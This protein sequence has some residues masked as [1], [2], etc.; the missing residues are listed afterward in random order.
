MARRFV[1]DYAQHFYIVFRVLI[2]LL[3]LAH[4]LQKFGI[5]G[6][7]AVA[8]G[9]L[10]WFAGVIELIVGTLVT[11]GLITRIAALLG[12]VE[13]VVAYFLVHLSKGL[14]P[15]TNNGE[16]AVLYFAA[17]LIL[18]AYGYQRWGLDSYF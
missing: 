14:N 10:F 9:T 8:F 16:P 11:V 17:F 12:A 2:G 4:G 1:E 6:G 15:L 18:I 5:F 13:M 7:N 3:F